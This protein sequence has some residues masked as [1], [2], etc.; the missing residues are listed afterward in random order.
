MSD[1]VGLECNV[2]HKTFSSGNLV[3]R[4]GWR[5]RIVS[6]VG[7]LA[8]FIRLLQSFDVLATPRHNVVSLCIDCAV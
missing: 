4:I 1:M 8:P 6:I 7:I 5:L 2:A 3:C